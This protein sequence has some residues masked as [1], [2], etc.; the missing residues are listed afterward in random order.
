MRSETRLPEV[1]LNW[2]ASEPAAIKVAIE[3]LLSDVVFDLETERYMLG[4]RLDEERSDLT[5]VESTRARAQ[6][7]AC[8]RQSAAKSALSPKA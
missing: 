5:L 7:R 8:R 2:W 4:S 1:R 6:T 3:G